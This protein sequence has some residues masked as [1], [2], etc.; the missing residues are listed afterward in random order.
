MPFMRLRRRV[1]LYTQQAYGGARLP[2]CLPEDRRRS[3]S[4]RARQQVM[5]I[6]RMD[7][8]RRLASI[9]A[10]GLAARVHRAGDHKRQLLE[11]SRCWSGMKSRITRG[12]ICCHAL[13]HGRTH[14]RLHRALAFMEGLAALMRPAPPVS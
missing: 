13:A 1:R 6:G 3:G 9:E 11:N 8:P 7:K 14:A 4:A 2:A 10:Q 5:C 12:P